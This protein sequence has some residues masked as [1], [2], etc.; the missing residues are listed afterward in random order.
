MKNT[1]AL[2]VVDVQ[3]DFCPGG[4]LAVPSGDTIIPAINKLLPQFELIIFTKDWHPVDAECFVSQHPG[5]QP[6]E[7][8]WPILRNGNDWHPDTQE[9]IWPDHCVAGT[10]GA[11]IHKD[12][13]FGK[14]A[15]DFYIFKKATDRSS[16]G[17]SGFEGTQLDEFLKEKGI[18]T[19]VVC[20]LATDYC[21]KNTA[22]DAANAGFRT[23]VVS[24]A[25]KAIS[26]DLNETE[27]QLRKNNVYYTDSNDLISFTL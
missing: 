14:C 20:G 10:P 13:D 25:C 5:K 11:D 24:D 17:Y 12:I 15:K 6:F 2:I 8:Y 9:T 19:V 23:V 7:Q 27:F 18:D 21:V 3:N 1:K 4:A 16:Q 26:P 22:I